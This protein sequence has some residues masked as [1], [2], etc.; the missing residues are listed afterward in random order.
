[1][2]AET[3]V[4]ELAKR[5]CA[6]WSNQQQAAENPPFWAHVRAFC[7]P[8]PSGLVDGIG[9]I[10]E[11]YYDFD[12]SRPYL[13]RIIGLSDR[14]GTLLSLPYS[15]DN[16]DQVRGGSRDT[17]KLSGLK[18]EMFSPSPEYCG[19]HFN[20]D[21]KTKTW[22]GATCPGKKCQSTFKG[23]KSYLDGRYD[24]SEDSF[25]TWDTGRDAETGQILWG[26]VA[27][28]FDFKKVEDF[29]SEVPAYKE[30]KTAS[31]KA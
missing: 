26:S 24:V 8:L 15:I 25:V 1:V 27:G 22:K 17:S 4:E 3:E 21:T 5:L 7:R 9:V 30:V 12:M 20:Y 2:N 13:C 10:Y 14:N 23:L 19:S 18:P 16:E 6:H 29:S 28:P 11:S 31:Q